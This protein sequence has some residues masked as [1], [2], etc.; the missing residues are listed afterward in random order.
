MGLFSSPAKVYK[1]AAEVD[2]GPGSDEH[3]I[4]PSVRAPPVAGLLVTLLAWV[5]ETP[6]LGWIVLTVLKRDNL[7]YKVAC[8]NL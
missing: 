8:S 7:V 6:V 2:L 1:P 4:S 3:D 5:L